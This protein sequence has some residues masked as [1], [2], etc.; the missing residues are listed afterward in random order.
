MNIDK[1][2]NKY[3]YLIIDTQKDVIHVLKSDRQVSELLVSIYDIKL[4]HMYIKRNLNNKDYILID[5]ILIK[6]IW[7]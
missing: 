2:Q 6:N 7:A 3:K 5:D 4:S 1:I